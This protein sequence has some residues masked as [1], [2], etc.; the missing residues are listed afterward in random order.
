MTFWLKQLI[1][2]RSVLALA[3]IK[4]WWQAHK[5]S[6]RR[7]IQVYAALLYNA[8]LK[9]F[10]QGEI[11]VG[12]TKNMCVPGFNCYSCPGAV[13]ACPLGALQNALAASDNRAPHYV[14]GILMLFGLTL[15]RTICGWLCPLGLIQE[16]LHRIP[17]PK[18]KKNR[19]TRVLSYLKYVILAVFVVIVPLMYSLQS[20]PVPAFCKYICPAGTLEGAIGLLANPVNADKFSML[21]ILFTRKFIIMVVILTACIF[22]YRAF[23]R[24]L[25][26]LGAIYGFFSRV[27]LLGVKVNPTACTDCGRCIAHCEMDVNRVGDH[28]CIQ[29]GRCMDVCP[30]K[31]ITW[32]GGKLL[33][34]KNAVNAPSVQENKKRF[35]IRAMVAWCAAL[36]VLFG[37]L[38]YF[39]RPETSVQAAASAGADGTIIETTP[40]VDDTP[41]GY[42]VGN[43]CPD[44]TVP[45]YGS[46][47]GEFT[48]STQS[49]KVTVINFWATWCTPCC[50]ELPY[51]QQLFDTYPD[52]VALVAIHSN[53][54]TNDVQAYLDKMG[55]TMPF[56]LDGDGNVIKSLGGS[57]MLP[58]TVITDRQGHIVYNT[59]GSVTYEK[60]ESIVTPLI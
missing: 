24:F 14:L 43:R 56:A 35:N 59:I 19:F 54:V 17:T 16:L 44:F 38:W 25:C 50:N 22:I 42:E 7:L 11:Y 27:A 8:N 9:G 58:M 5:P 18:V 6:T 10:I 48:L 13:G 23:C 46:D 47:G 12:P 34:H 51:F 1:F 40:M 39:N 32:K 4:E 29:C 33:L 20:F 55:Y 26:P 31:A 60:L 2:V 15:G 45:L 57:T 30:E 53:L 36:I 41:E 52:D 49:G 37:A 21:G 3:K 28:E